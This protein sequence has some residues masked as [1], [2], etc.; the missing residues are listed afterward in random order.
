MV[1]IDQTGL[2]LDELICDKLDLLWIDSYAI[3]PVH[4]IQLATN[5]KLTQLGMSWFQTKWLRRNQL[6]CDVRAPQSGPTLLF[7]CPN[8]DFYM[9]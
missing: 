9:P 5:K 7:I 3:T 6:A 1:C 4:V 2:I 8:I